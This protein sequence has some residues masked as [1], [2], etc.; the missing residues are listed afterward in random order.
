M[1]LSFAMKTYFEQNLTLF[2][3]KYFGFLYFVGDFIEKVYRYFVLE[4]EMCHIY[5][6]NGICV[7]LNLTQRKSSIYFLLL[8]LL[9][10]Q[11]INIDI[12]F[13][14]TP[15]KRSLDF[16]SKTTYI[17][18]NIDNRV[19]DFENFSPIWTKKIEWRWPM[20]NTFA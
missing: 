18:V 10:D 5:K 4:I 1:L 8:S 20:M 2:T 16:N 11:N 14:R 3:V 6:W 12:I 15:F 13:V 19:N 17:K 9:K 7:T